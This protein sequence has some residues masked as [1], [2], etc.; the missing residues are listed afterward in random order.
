M[1]HLGSS[2]VDVV[3]LFLVPIVQQNKIECFSLERLNAKTSNL[4]H[5]G[6]SAVN[7]VNLFSEPI[8]QQNKI[9]VFLLKE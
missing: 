8:V 2:A 9:D 1:R 7:I 6:S 4:R 3:N 5:W